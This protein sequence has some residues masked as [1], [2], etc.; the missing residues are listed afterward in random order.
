[1]YKY[2]LMVRDR[3]SVAL[4]NTAR[5]RR[6]AKRVFTDLN[7]LGNEAN[8]TDD[9]IVTKTGVKMTQQTMCACT[10]AMEM[11]CDTM[12]TYLNQCFSLELA[13]PEEFLMHFLYSRF[14]YQM[15]SVNR[16]ILVRGLIEDL[17]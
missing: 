17:C 5:Q 7:I 11:T 2:E 13:R 3:I 4:K 14:S 12:V 6:G 8:Y 10:L 9:C 16:K 15:Y 1:M